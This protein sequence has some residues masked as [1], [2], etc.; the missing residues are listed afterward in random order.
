MPQKQ[1]LTFSAQLLQNC[2]ICFHEQTHL[3][4]TTTLLSSYFFCELPF[5]TEKTE[6]LK[7]S[8]WTHE[9]DKWRD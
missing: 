8:L 7:V 6:A 1:Q 3:I 4:F 5:E 2:S 9:A